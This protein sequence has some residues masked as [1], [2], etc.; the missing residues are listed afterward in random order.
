VARWASQT[1]ANNFVVPSATVQHYLRTRFPLHTQGAATAGT[2]L[3]IQS[4]YVRSSSRAHVHWF[5]LAAGAAAFSLLFIQLRLVDDIDDFDRDARADTAVSGG[6]RRRLVIGL[7][8]IMTAVILLSAWR[9]QTLTL[10]LATSLLMLLAPVV[11][12]HPRLP[13][14]RLILPLVYEGAPALIMLYGYVAWKAYSE[15]SSPWGLVVGV[16]GL[17]WAGYEFWKFSRKLDQ[18]AYRPYGLGRT[19]RYAVL[20]TL[21]IVAGCCSI[22]IYTSSDL[23]VGVLVYGLLVP[24]VFAGWMSAWWARSIPGRRDA[25]KSTASPAWAGLTFVLILVAGLL[26]GT[27]ISSL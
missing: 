5:A 12:K 2:F 15:V 7:M 11:A 23:P 4:L 13:L 14:H 20:M 10:V 24:L 27:A 1:M 21:L 22:L 3:C 17:F 16:T 18:E 26:A 25:T 9:W 19:G 6:S 8:T